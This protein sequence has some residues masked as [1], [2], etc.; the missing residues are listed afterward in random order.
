VIR[1][2]RQSIDPTLA[3]QHAPRVAQLHA[4][5]DDGTAIPQSV[6]D[7][8]KADGLKIHLRSESSDKCAYCESKITHVYWGDVEHIRPK[9][10][11]PRDRLD[12]GNLCIACAKCNNLKLDYWSDELPLV[13]P[14]I[15]EPADELVSFGAWIARQPGSDRGRM[16]VSRLGLN[17]P[18][19][20]ERRQERWQLLQPLADQYMQTPEGATRNLIRQELVEQARP[21]REFAM[22][23]RAYLLLVC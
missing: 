10:L 22:V 14:F 23:V 9:S 19:L 17:R 4:C 11:F 15:D 7:A 3:A 16:T 20:L 13:N 1:L 5:L 18:E 6:L 21:D 2:A 12:V 8:Y